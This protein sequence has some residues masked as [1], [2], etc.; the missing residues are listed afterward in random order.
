MS[1]LECLTI[2]GLVTG[3]FVYVMWM[4]E[5]RNWPSEQATTLEAVLRE[6]IGI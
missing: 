3:I 6:L 4:F 5:H 1:Y 2:I